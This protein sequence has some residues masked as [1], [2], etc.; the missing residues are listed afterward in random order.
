M[1]GNQRSSNSVFGQAN[2]ETRAST[3]ATAVSK[4]YGEKT[5]LTDAILVVEGHVQLHCSKDVSVADKRL[6]NKL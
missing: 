3:P 5:E 4:K 2:D 6:L 1:S